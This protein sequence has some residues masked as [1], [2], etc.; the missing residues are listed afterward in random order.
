[1][2]TKDIT[3]NLALAIEVEPNE[4]LGYKNYYALGYTVM[5]KDFRKF[6][7]VTPVADQEVT[8]AFDNEPAKFYPSKMPD[9]LK[10]IYDNPVNFRVQELKSLAYFLPIQD[11]S[12]LRKQPLIEEIESWK[13]AYNEGI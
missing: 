12:A 3:K 6:T 13:V 1:M 11:A 8:A 7:N 5:L 9:H 4:I 10:P 2:T